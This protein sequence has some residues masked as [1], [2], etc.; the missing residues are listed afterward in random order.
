MIKFDYELVPL[1]HTKDVST[2]TLKNFEGFTASP[3]NKGTSEF[4]LV[5]RNDYFS[6]SQYFLG[7]LDAQPTEQKAIEAGHV[8]SFLQ[9]LARNYNHEYRVGTFEKETYITY[10][11]NNAPKCH[12]GLNILKN[13]LDNFEKALTDLENYFDKCFD[14]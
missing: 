14:R 13:A 11:S 12:S 7:I 10:N 2:L 9:E 5:I 8:H 6:S 3:F 1:A 4:Y